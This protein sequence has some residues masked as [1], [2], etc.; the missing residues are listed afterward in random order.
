MA[1]EVKSDKLSPSTGTS[2]QL[3]DAS[4]TI[5]IPTGATFTVTDGLGVASGG[6]GLA[7]FT[8]GDILYASGTTTLTKLAKGTA[9]Q[10][11]AMNSGAT[12][13]DWGSVDLTVLPTITAAKGGTGQT[14]YT[15]GDTVYASG[16]TAVSKL[17][18]GTARQG[19]QTN[20]GATAPEWVN[21]P[22]SL[23]TAAGD[24]LY[25]SGAN[26]LAKL[27][28]GSDDE[29]LTLASGVPSWA[30]AGGG[31]WNLIKTQTI[32][33]TT[34]S[35]DF[36][37][38]TSDVVFDGTYKYYKVLFSNA[39]VDTTAAKFYVRVR[40]GGSFVTSGYMAAE[41]AIK[42]NGSTGATTWDSTTAAITSTGCVYLPGAEYAFLGE[43][44]FEDPSNTATRKSCIYQTMT[45]F[46][47]GSN[48]RTFVGSGVYSTA[49][50]ITGFQLL[51]STGNW[52]TLIASLY[53]LSS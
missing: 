42:F 44:M 52:E 28:K 9:E 33:S 27:A 17:G 8:A 48:I 16:S 41:L 25:A 35:M 7:S 40:S 49:G 24:I 45:P 13:P 4:D 18:I 3:G 34:A 19:L 1:S 47:N 43:L 51:L 12:A 11:L 37:D 38:G 31:A 2:L 30:A 10:V 26:T 32:S 50:A 39:T 29:V 20:S 6:T 22:Q 21:S 53:G 14:S 36:I 23:M 46:D 15:T 5:T